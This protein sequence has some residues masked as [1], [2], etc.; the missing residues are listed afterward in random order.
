MPSTWFPSQW[1]LEE[2]WSSSFSPSASSSSLHQMMQTS[3]S[4]PSPRKLSPFWSLRPILS[5]KLQHR[6]LQLQQAQLVHQHF[7][8]RWPE[9]LPHPASWWRGKSWSWIS[10]SFYF[11]R[12]WSSELEYIFLLN[13]QKFGL[14]C[15]VSCR[16]YMVHKIWAPV[17]TISCVANHI[18]H[19]VYNY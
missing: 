17:E 15:L 4:T 7:A 9:L 12:F 11:G 14:S 8:H 3:F 6:A 18:V 2:L 16:P 13:L 19:T 5:T 1:L 10:I